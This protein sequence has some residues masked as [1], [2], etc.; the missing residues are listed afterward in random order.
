MK[1]VD[2]AL[3]ELAAIAATRGMVGA[4]LAL[5]LGDCLP[6]EQKKAIGWGLLLAGALSTIPLGM[7]V[8]RKAR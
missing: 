4:G 8:L 6:A 2:L 5:L 7:S 3:P 1:H